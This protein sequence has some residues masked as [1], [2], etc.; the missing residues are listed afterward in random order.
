MSPLPNFVVCPACRAP[1]SLTGSTVGCQNQ[2]QFDV[3]NGYV[4]FLSGRRATDESWSASFDH[5]EEARGLAYRVDNFL[6]PFIQ[7]RFGSTPIRLLDDGAGYGHIVALLKERGVD[8]YGVDPGIRR[9]Q[10]S[11]L[12]LADRLF[13]ADGRNLP[14]EEEVFDV[15]F[16]SGVLEHVGDPLPP[17]AARSGPCAQYIHEVVRVLKPGGVA[18]IAHPNGW[19]PMRIHSPLQQWMPRPPDVK[20]WVRSSPIPATSSFVSP[21]GFLAFERVRAHLYGRV[22][23]RGMRLIFALTKRFPVLAGSPLNP[24]LVTRIERR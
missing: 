1:V 22:F 9:E 12:G 19:H 11:Q 20:R 8:A 17:G 4:D 2:H 15:V 3:V 21:T 24:W 10:W 14:F 23:A 16:S 13:A 7:R 6:I 5:G 18:L